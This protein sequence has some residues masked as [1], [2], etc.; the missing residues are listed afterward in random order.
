MCSLHR[1]DY[2]REL[3]TRANTLAKI[4]N[5]KTKWWTCGGHKHALTYLEMG[6][7]V[8]DFCP[9][10]SHSHVPRTTHDY[11]M[12][13][14]P[15]LPFFGAIRDS[16]NR[17]WTESDIEFNSWTLSQGGDTTR[18]Q[19]SLIG[20]EGTLQWDSHFVK[21]FSL[22]QKSINSSRDRATGTFNAYSNIRICRSGCIIVKF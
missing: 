8:L 17:N 19:E 2:R 15:N 3:F 20:F 11:K 1:A 21:W 5:P 16:F 18:G 22:S 7:R 4:A 10:F 13:T 9:I 6:W 12:H 14:F